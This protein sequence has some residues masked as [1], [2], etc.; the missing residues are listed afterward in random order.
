MIQDDHAKAERVRSA[1][2][3]DRPASD[4]SVTAEAEELPPARAG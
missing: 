1:V 3:D 4:P 2:F